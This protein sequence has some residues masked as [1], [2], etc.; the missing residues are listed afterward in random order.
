LIC[1]VFVRY[2]RFVGC[3]FASGFEDFGCPKIIFLALA[4]SALFGVLVLV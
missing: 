2:I 3:G 4:A 1:Y